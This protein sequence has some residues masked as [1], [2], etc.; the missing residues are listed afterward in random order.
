MTLQLGTLDQ[1]LPGGIFS[2]PVTA[3]SHQ[4]YAHQSHPLEKS[5]DDTTIES[6]AEQETPQI[7]KSKITKTRVP[8]EIDK[9]R[10]EIP[11]YEDYLPDLEGAVKIEVK[12]YYKKQQSKKHQYKKRKRT[13]SS[14]SSSSSSSTSSSSSSNITSD[15]NNSSIEDNIPLVEKKA[16]KLPIEKH[17]NDMA[18]KSKKQKSKSDTKVDSSSTKAKKPKKSPKKAVGK[19]ISQKEKKNYLR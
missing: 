13:I 19:K 5:S 7:I 8:D 2:Q 12:K 1:S 9:Q 18:G 16:E 3:F 4:K 15:Q 17:N 14:S 11:I 10:E 6:E